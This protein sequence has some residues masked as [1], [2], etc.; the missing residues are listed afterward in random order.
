M[1]EQM[2]VI[3][4][5]NWYDIGR[6]LGRAGKPEPKFDSGWTDR[7]IAAYARGWMDGRRDRVMGSS[8][9]GEATK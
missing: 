5:L 1:I 9:T 3:S 7:A 6:E 2:E 4:K 8:E